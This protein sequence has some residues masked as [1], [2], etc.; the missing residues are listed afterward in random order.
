VE[1]WAVTNWLSANPF[2]V[3]AKDPATLT[4]AQI[5]KELDRLDKESRKVV[6]ELIDAGRGSETSHETMTMTDP[7]ARQYQAVWERQADLHEEVR[8]R[9]GPDAPSRLPIK[10]G[11]WGPRR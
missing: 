11:W 9:Y 2:R 4:A 5:N 8:R 6:E 10:R 1:A 3:G 7:L